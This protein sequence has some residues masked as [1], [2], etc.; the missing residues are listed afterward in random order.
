[1]TIGESDERCGQPI[2]RVDAV[3]LAALDEGGDHRPV[4]AAF[5]RAGEQRIFAIQGQGPDASL[6]RIGIQVDAPIVEEVGEPVPA[7]ERIADRLGKLALGADLAKPSVEIDAQVVDDTAAA[8]VASGA[9]LL[10]QEAADLVL[11]DAELGDPPEHV[12]GNRRG[13]RQLVELASDVRPAERQDDLLPSASQRGIAAI[14]I[15]LEDAGERTEVGR[16]P[17]GPF[18]KLRTCLRSAA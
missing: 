7:C 12:F 18:D 13:R 3:Q 6:D 10:G 14:A 1:M 17:F 16:G 15:D 2:V 5:V 11:D 9:T 4:V 8:L